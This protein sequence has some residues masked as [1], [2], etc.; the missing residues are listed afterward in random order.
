MWQVL[1]L[2]PTTSDLSPYQS[3]SAF[4]GNPRFISIDEIKK[5]PWCRAEEYADFVENTGLDNAKTGDEKANWLAFAYSQFK[6]HAAVASND[7]LLREFQCFCQDQEVW[8]EEY[9]LYVVLKERFQG[10]SWVDWPVSLRDRK[11]HVL[12]GARRRYADEIQFVK[13]VQFV[14][15]QQWMCLKKYA[16]K[17]NI[18]I[19]GD[20]PLF[21]SHDSADVWVNRKLFKLDDDGQLIFV[22]GVP[23]DYFS[24]TG[25]RWGNPVYDWVNHEA[26]DFAWWV[27]RL[28]HQFALFD[29]VR[30]DHFRGL[31]SYWEIPAEHETALKGCWVSAPGRKMLSAVKA[32]FSLQCGIDNLPLVA[33]DL[34][35]ITAEVNALKAAF[36]LPGMK[37]LQFAFGGDSSNPYLPHNHEVNSVVYTGT[38]DNNTTL[39][40]FNGLDEQLKSHIYRY[41]DSHESMPWLLI[42]S[43]YA[44]VADIVVVPMQDLM[45]LGEEGRMNIPGTTQGNWL[46]RFQWQ[47]LDEPRVIEYVNTLNALYGR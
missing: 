20:L 42:R 14:F 4:A 1:P 31:E 22:A 10:R 36:G 17:R 8:L 21:V 30:I 2:G 29:D 26:E 13:F 45:G 34:G 11:P 12:R 47:E 39:G 33:E 6:S 44:S 35:L 38:H 24:E 27:Q 46:W 25:Q 40:W 19:F 16:N 15:F 18:R 43:A 23:P 28:A 3:S 9:A 5:K 7:N 41:F 32:Y 37:I